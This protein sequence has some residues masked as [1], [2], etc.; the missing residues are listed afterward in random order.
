MRTTLE[1]HLRPDRQTPEDA[2]A[3]YCEG[4]IEVLLA[5]SASQLLKDGTRIIKK[6]GSAV[7]DAALGHWS[8]AIA[9][10][11]DTLHAAVELLSN[12]WDARLPW[13]LQP[14]RQV[15]HQYL[16]SSDGEMQ[17]AAARIFKLPAETIDKRLRDLD[18]ALRHSVP[19]SPIRRTSS[20]KEPYRLRT[21]G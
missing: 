3:Q 8:S 21:A 2:T 17:R 11:P 15:F 1:K 5:N 10:I 12:Q 18:V 6:S 14:L 20:S 16:L 4:N 9:K 7:G 19:W 13:N